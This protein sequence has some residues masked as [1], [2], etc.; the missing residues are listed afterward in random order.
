[1]EE[2]LVCGTKHNLM[3]KKRTGELGF[4]PAPLCLPARRSTISLPSRQN[5]VVQETCHTQV[6]YGIENFRNGSN[7]KLEFREKEEEYVSQVPSL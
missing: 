2:L 4:E 1:M 7:S 6:E 3:R 5:V